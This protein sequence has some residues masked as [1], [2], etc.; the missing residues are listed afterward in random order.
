MKKALK[1]GGIV[2][3][4]LLIVLLLAPFLFKGSLEDLLKKNLNDN[5]NATVIWESLDLSFFR[6]FPN[7]A[8]QLNDY[9]VINHAPFE[10]DTLASGRSLELDMGISQLFK[11][12]RSPIE[13]NALL[14]DEAYI[15]IVKDSLGNANYD[16]AKKKKDESA[17]E[18]ESQPT[19]AGFTFAL[20]SYEI[21]NS[22]IYYTDE[23]DK[24]LFQ[25]DQFNHKGTGDLSADITTL[26]TETQALATFTS[27]NTT[28][29]KETRLQWD[30]EFELDLKNNRYTFK[31]NEA[32]INELPLTF[33]GFIQ[34]DEETTQVDL[35]FQTPSSDFKNF[36]GVIPKAYVSDLEGVTTTGDFTVNGMVNGTIDES[37]V[38][39]MDIRVSSENASF[40]YP[41]LPKAVRNI[42]IS[43]QLKNETGLPQD[44]YLDIAGVR[45]K[46]DDE[47]FAAS[48]NI[49]NLT[50][51][52]LVQLAIQG[53]LDLA[54][55][56][57]IIPLE[58]EQP[59]SGVFTADV[60]TQFDMASIDNEQYQNI[61][62]NGTASLRNFTYRDEAFANDLYIE[63]AEA[64]LAPGNIRID[65]LKASTGET[66]VDATGTVQNLIPW[67]MAKQD[68]KGRFTVRSNI[69]NVNDFMSASS[70]EPAKKDSDTNKNGSSEGNPAQEGVKIPDFLD[71]TLDFTANTVRYDNVELKNASGTVSIKDETAR[72]SNV[73]SN[74]Y[75]GAIAFSGDVSTVEATPVFTMDLDLQSL[76]IDQ[77]FSQLELL[78]YLAPIGRALDGDLNSQIRLSGELN[79]NLSPKLSSLSGNAIAQIIA[80]KVNPGES[81]LLTK[82]GEQLTFVDINDL[83]L[84]D[85]SAALN[86]NDGK[87]TVDPFDFEVEDFKVSVSGSH[88]LNKQIDYNATVDVPAKY[89]GSDVR[90]LLQSLEPQEAENMSIALPISIGGSLNQPTVQLDTRTAVNELTQQIIAKQKEELVNQGTDILEDFLGQNSS[91]DST[92]TN[93]NNQQ[94]TEIVK[95]VLGGLFK[96]KKKESDST[97]QGN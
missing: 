56:E 28:Y 82:L 25:L 18:D 97:N 9:I 4:L 78:K 41:E 2:M 48:G 12:S 74:L 26:E 35:Q 24:T 61:K 27:G 3:M 34:T 96:K 29:G 95:D 19:E 70:D 23:A 1:I 31:D 65:R 53:T 44:T 60:N 62:S 58:L 63:E 49:R 16:I 59:L 64:S 68:L 83:N 32:R 38:P 20:N 81:A 86:F 87:I 52:A 94:A 73:T 30:A 6:N 33:T 47:L 91:K 67:I 93:N 71:A 90:K 36:L 76:D 66:D 40:K 22:R 72:L 17:T 57:Q 89:L 7:V 75:G 42:S 92:Q 51:N 39:K 85:I 46:I 10:G 55:I 88:Q 8:V 45:F 37:H 80:A 69:F 43:A 77:S 79:E 54:N 15:N 84:N 5:L 50:E 11:G 13:V 21:R 14:L